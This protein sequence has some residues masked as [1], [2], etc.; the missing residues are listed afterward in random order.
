[1][2]RVYNADAAET[3]LM[4]AFPST[5]T[6]T[7]P[8]HT[9]TLIFPDGSWAT[10]NRI[11]GSIETEV[12][13]ALR[14]GVRE[15]R[16][17]T[18]VSNSYISFRNLPEQF[19]RVM[20]RPSPRPTPI[21]S[22]R[23][24]LLLNLVDAWRCVLEFLDVETVIFVPWWGRFFF[25]ARNELLWGVLYG[26]YCAEGDTH[27]IDVD[28]NYRDLLLHVLTAFK[29]P[30]GP[31]DLAQ[32]LTALPYG[33]AVVGAKKYLLSGAIGF[34]GMV[35]QERVRVGNSRSFCCH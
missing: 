19:R 30:R 32:Y 25:E 8:F 29:G 23:R 13:H 15:I 5:A 31:P 18:N 16:E 9:L 24:C 20:T 6:T 21:D 33:S 12:A 26:R 7:L 17:H 11:A 4:E 14:L 34:S 1:M 3:A 22:S 2:K 10:S 27:H 28:A 35:L